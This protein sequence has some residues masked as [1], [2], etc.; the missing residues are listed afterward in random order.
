MPNLKT[1][2]LIEFAGTVSERL[3]SSFEYPYEVLPHIG[4]YIKEIGPKLDKRVYQQK[5]ENIWIA[6]TAKIAD[7]ARYIV[8]KEKGIPMYYTE[9]KLS[10]ELQGAQCAKGLFPYEL[11]QKKEEPNIWRINT[12]TNEFIHSDL[13]TPI[14]VGFQ[15]T[16][17]SPDASFSYSAEYNKET[18]EL[19][20]VTFAKLTIGQT[21]YLKYNSE[22]GV[23]YIRY[24]NSNAEKIL[25][26]ITTADT[27]ER[28]IQQWSTKKF[29]IPG[30]F[31]DPYF[32]MEGLKFI[33]KAENLKE[34]KCNSFMCFPRT[35]II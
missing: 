17:N 30:R 26:L 22:T 27:G 2:D 10:F 28:I 34:Y 20:S 23:L 29:V 13:S 6:K 19:F 21:F 4:D 14:E 5:G 25:S 8:G 33:G 11:T 24:G 35:N 31:E 12:E 7:S 3:L 15:I 18:V 9:L 1:I 32:N 16:P